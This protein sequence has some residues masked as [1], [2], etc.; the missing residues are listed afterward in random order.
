MADKADRGF[1]GDNREGFGAGRAGRGAGRFDRGGCRFGRGT[2]RSDRGGS[3][4]SWKRD[5]FDN[6]RKADY[7]T[8]SD[9]SRWDAA[10]TAE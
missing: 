10:A 9:T 4:F 7:S 2:G 1:R 8:A 3:R 6:D 5:G